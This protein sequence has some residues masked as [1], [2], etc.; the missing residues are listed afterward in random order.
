[1]STKGRL[2]YRNCFINTLWGCLRCARIQMTGVSSLKEYFKI[3]LVSLIDEVFVAT[4]ACA[5][6]CMSLSATPSFLFLWEGKA[7]FIL[8][9]AL[10][11]ESLWE[12][13]E[14]TTRSRA[15]QQSQWPL[16][17]S[18]HISYWYGKSTKVNFKCIS[19]CPWVFLPQGKIKHF[20]SLAVLPHQ[21]WVD[22]SGCQRRLCM[23][24]VQTL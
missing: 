5:F 21:I 13:C 24:Q 16:C 17:Y 15:G 11:F 19:P 14:K 2:C 1:M 10:S 22:M 7:I 9:R 20:W 6:F 4:K 12:T 18:R 3:A 8:H 23:L